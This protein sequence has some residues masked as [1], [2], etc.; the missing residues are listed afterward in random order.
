VL[1]ELPD[2]RK[3]ASLS[4]GLHRDIFFVS[5]LFQGEKN[6]ESVEDG[7]YLYMVLERGTY[8]NIKV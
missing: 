7:Y 8:I 2:E 6:E 1:V 5:C 3:G 4:P